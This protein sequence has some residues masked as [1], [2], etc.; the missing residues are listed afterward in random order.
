[1]RAGWTPADWPKVDYL[2]WRESRCVPGLISTTGDYGLLQ[3][4]LR[5][6][7]TPGYAALCARTSATRVPICT[8]DDL[9]RPRRGLRA[10]RILS[11]VALSWFGNRW[12]PWGLS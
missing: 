5:H 11:D 12:Q 8:A 2:L 3:V 4:N 9:L 6:L 10:A 7:S 1:M